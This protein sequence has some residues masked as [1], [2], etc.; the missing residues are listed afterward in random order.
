M[1]LSSGADWILI[2]ENQNRSMREKPNLFAQ[3]VPWIIQKLS[4]AS[5]DNLFRSTFDLMV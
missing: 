5:L 2:M 4:K 3:Y 1:E